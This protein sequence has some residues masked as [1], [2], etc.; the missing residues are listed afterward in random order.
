MLVGLGVGCESAGTVWGVGHVGREKLPPP[1]VLLAWAWCRKW[2]S[3]CS[4]R[5]G[6]A[7]EPG[8]QGLGVQLCT[9]DSGTG[10]EFWKM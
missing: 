6:C 2:Q 10:T 7:R 3:W 5:G 8:G 4:G 9:R 1:R